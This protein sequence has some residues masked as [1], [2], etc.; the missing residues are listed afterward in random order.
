MC[1]LSVM[2]SHFSGVSGGE[3]EPP[4]KD[5]ALSADGSP[6]S[7]KSRQNSTTS[8]DLAGRNLTLSAEDQDV[9]SVEAV[10]C[11]SDT[12]SHEVRRD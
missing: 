10:S 8:E 7:D 3:S 1:S 6:D 2:R 5:N 4:A 12:L 11:P 9:T